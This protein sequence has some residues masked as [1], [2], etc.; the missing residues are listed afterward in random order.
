MIKKI[1]LIA[2]VLL[3]VKV[4]VAISNSSSFNENTPPIISN[5][6][7]E[8]S[9]P[10]R[11]YFD[12]SEPITA[13]NTTGFVVSGKTL[14]GI[15]INSNQ[16]TNHYF[17]ITSNFTFWDN[18]TI[19][20]E[21]GSDFEDIDTNPLENIDLQYI[22]NN[23]VEPTSSTYKYVSTSG[24]GT[25][26][27]IGSPCSLSYAFDNATAGETWWVKA[28]NYTGYGNILNSGRATAP[29]K[30]IGYDTS[31]NDLNDVNFEWGGS[32]YGISNVMNTSDAPTLSGQTVINQDYIILRNFQARNGNEMI[33]ASGNV[34]L[35]LDNIYADEG[36]SGGTNVK[37]LN[38]S[39]SRLINSTLRNWGTHGT[40]TYNGGNVLWENN[41]LY[42]DRAIGGDYFFHISGSNNIVRGCDIYKT[43]SLGS[44]QHGFSVKSVLGSAEYNLIENCTSSSSPFPIEA[45]WQG[46]KYNVW[47]NI[48]INNDPLINTK[49]SG[50]A[51]V[52]MNGASYNTFDKITVTRGLAGIRFLSS[53]EKIDAPTAGHDNVFKNCIFNN[54]IYG[55]YITEDTDGQN[56]ETYNNY[57]QNCTFYNVNTMF[58][59]ESD[60][61]RDNHFINCSITEVTSKEATTS[62]PIGWDYQNSNFYNNSSYSNPV[63]NGNI[64]DNP[65]FENPSSGD[66]RLKSDSPL[67][68]KGKNLANVSFDFDGVLRPQGSSTDIGAFEKKNENSNSVNANAGSDITICSG[69]STTLTASGGVSYSWSTG[70]TTQSISVSPT[71]TTTY[72]VTVSNGSDSDSDDVIVTVNEPPT[73]TVG[74]D[75]TLCLGDSIT[76]TTEGNGNFVWSTGETTSSITVSPSTTTTY[77]VTSTNACDTNGVSDEIVIT[78][79]DAPNIDAGSDVTIEEGSSTTLTAIGDG[80]FLWSTGETDSSI[81]VSPVTTT[82]Y[83]VT[84][85]SNGGCTNDDSVT[86]IVEGSSQNDNDGNNNS[87]NVEANAGTDVE[88]CQNSPSIILTASGGD[89]YLWNTGE[90]TASITVNPIETTTYSVTVSNSSSIDSD[91]VTVFVDDS[92]SGLGNRSSSKEILIYPNPTNG[93]LNVELSG[94]NNSIIISLFSLNGSM[95]YS[96]NINNYSPDKILKRQIDLSKFGKGVYFVRLTNNNTSETKKVLVI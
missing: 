67:I 48:S 9:T 38:T 77:S 21:G 30:F 16:T 3:N 1:L 49:A 46:V 90:I 65:K 28:G 80:N 56:R 84:A 61:V 45:R 32:P 81:T 35:E 47:R 19:R 54:N 20:Y 78:V 37:F 89:N 22:D 2:F 74:S 66:F 44:G 18:N 88:I 4:S 23:I 86:V 58:S 51:I 34:G 24:S 43:T 15:S 87:T 69:A 41:V 36:E 25:T 57:V 8:K 60:D 52:I 85:T 79:S 13:S 50:G 5:F 10:N 17:T 27:S 95:V 29:I 83:T 31:I 73:V 26:C 11:V 96:E 62:N 59:N 94:F 76:I 53:P 70:E 82:T 33:L 92:C 7:I 40:L 72:S 42:Q 68:D 75:V 39:N 91:E 6:R 93:L 55:I 14:S 64:S 71:S 12:S 63:G